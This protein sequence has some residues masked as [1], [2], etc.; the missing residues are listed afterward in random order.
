[1]GQMYSAGTEPLYWRRPA[2]PARAR[3]AAA[4]I[5][6]SCRLSAVI[7]ASCACMRSFCAWWVFA[8]A[9]KRTRE[10]LSPHSKADSSHSLWLHCP[11]TPASATACRVHLLGLRL[12]G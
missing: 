2:P 11:A 8:C 7:S 5:P 12:L 9:V 6:S 3:E 10:S 4:C 1:M